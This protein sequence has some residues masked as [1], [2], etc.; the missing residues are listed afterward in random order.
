MWMQAQP[1][2]SDHKPAPRRFPPFTGRCHTCPEFRA[3]ILQSLRREPGPKR[4]GRRREHP[5]H[6]R[7]RTDS[8]KGSRRPLPPVGSFLVKWLQKLQAI[9]VD[10]EAIV[11]LMRLVIALALFPAQ[12]A[13]KVFLRIY[14]SHFSPPYFSSGKTWNSSRYQ[15]GKGQHPAPP[16][17]N[18]GVLSWLPCSSLRFAPEIWSRQPFYFMGNFLWRWGGGVCEGVRYS[19]NIPQRGRINLTER[20]DRTCLHTTAAQLG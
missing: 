6:Q 5:S 20:R 8:P 11:D 7:Q 10:K 9:C 14:F 15:T 18:P 17:T 13:T 16:P 3:C 19:K 2:G 12:I 1:P 4:G